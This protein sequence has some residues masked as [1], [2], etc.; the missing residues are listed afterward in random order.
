VNSVKKCIALL[1]LFV[2]A[3]SMRA[4]AHEPSCHIAQLDLQAYEAAL[5]DY[6]TTHGTLPDERGWLDALKR[7]QLISAKPRTFD[8]WGNPYSFRISKGDFDLR[9]VGPDGVYGSADD[10]VRTNRWAWTQCREP[11]RRW[12]WGGCGG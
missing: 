7:D 11:W 1:C 6:A 9:T 8:P 12:L 10:Q 5:E 4:S 3:F 2:M